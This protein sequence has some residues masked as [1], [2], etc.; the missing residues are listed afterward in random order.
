MALTTLLICAFSLGLLSYAQPEPSE[1]YN[2]SDLLSTC[3]KI[4][5]AISGASQVFFP[6]E[7][8]VFFIGDTTISWVIKLRL[9]TRWTLNTLFCRVPRRPLAQWSLAPPRT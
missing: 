3:N 8:V 7:R 2:S 6:R 4:S 1:N 5:A 9:S